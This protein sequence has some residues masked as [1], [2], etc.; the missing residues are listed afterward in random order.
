MTAEESTPSYGY[1]SLSIS[2]QYVVV[3]STEPEVLDWCLEEA[4]RQV[5]GKIQTNWAGYPQRRWVRL[6]LNKKDPPNMRFWLFTQLCHSGWEPIS[7]EHYEYK[8]RKK[9]K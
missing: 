5:K 9:L 6:L 7:V 2:D 1:L 8:L 3:E 4:E